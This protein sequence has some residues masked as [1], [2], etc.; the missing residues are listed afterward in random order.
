MGSAAH[1]AVGCAATLGL[2][3]GVLAY[4]SQ[5]PGSQLFGRTLIAGSDPDEF[6]LTFDDGPNPAATP[7]LLEVLA[8]YKVR[9]DVFHDRGLCAAGACAGAGGCCG[10][11]CDREPYHVASAAFCIAGRTGQ[12]GVG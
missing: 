1:V 7:Q 3:A 12:S 9:G 11:A 5:W 2:A 6:A 8:R 4:A 10:G